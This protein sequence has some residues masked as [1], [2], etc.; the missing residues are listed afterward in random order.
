MTIDSASMYRRFE[1]LKAFLEWKELCTKD[2]SL[3]TREE[4]D[5]ARQLAGRCKDE[6][7][8][9]RRRTLVLL[10]AQPAPPAAVPSPP[11]SPQ[12]S[13]VEREAVDLE[14]EVQQ[15]SAH[16]PP[17]PAVAIRPPADAVP[18]APSS[19]SSLL[20]HPPA[21]ADQG[22]IATLVVDLLAELRVALDA[23]AAMSTQL[24]DLSA[25]VAGLCNKRRLQEQVSSVAA[26]VAD[27]NR[28]CDD[29]APPDTAVAPPSSAVGGVGSAIEGGS[30]VV[31]PDAEVANAVPDAL[32]APPASRPPSSSCLKIN[33][34]RLQEQVDRKDD[35][36]APADT[37]PTP[38]LSDVGGLGSVV[39]PDES[40]ASLQL[41]LPP[42][43]FALRPAA[44]P[45]SVSQAASTPESPAVS[46]AA[47]LAASPAASPAAPLAVSPAAPPPALTHEDAVALLDEQAESWLE[48]MK[49]AMAASPDCVRVARALNAVV[50]CAL[51]RIEATFQKYNLKVGDW[52]K[53]YN[54]K[55]NIKSHE[56]VNDDVAFQSARQYFMTY[57]APWQA[58]E[59]E[60]RGM[61]PLN[62]KTKV[63][64]E[65]EYSREQVIHDL[66]DLVK[67]VGCPPLNLEDIEVKLKQGK[68]NGLNDSEDA[69]LS[70][71]HGALPENEEGL[72]Y[73]RAQLNSDMDA[74]RLEKKERKQKERRATKKRKTD[75][76]AAMGRVTRAKRQE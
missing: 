20:P 3:S 16:R 11:S 65:A 1:S 66:I 27:L 18:H 74:L 25:Q 42:S 37:T 71:L 10:A 28:K 36:P 76:G 55:K 21:S 58:A 59:R 48:G 19:P 73:L 9:A 47:P 44:P 60:A 34:R 46:P 38:P 56:Q 54:R 68:Y 13:A 7:T 57:R 39:L 62:R 29:P 43:P 14:E 63:E 75:A 51:C 33:N 15:P 2:R 70:K 6:A 12:L 61:P 72:G 32:P 4:K 30:G 69:V 52:L 17:S 24:T 26:D 31:L 40:D 49:A 22:S 64:K 8:W 45:S 23:Q 53:V 67:E 35:D 41:D 5:T 50:I